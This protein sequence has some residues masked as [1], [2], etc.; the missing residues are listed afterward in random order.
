MNTVEPGEQE[1][2]RQALVREAVVND[3]PEGL[4]G[5]GLAAQVPGVKVDAVVDPQLVAL[6]RACDA[7]VEIERFLVAPAFIGLE[8]LVDQ[9]RGDDL[10][11]VVGVDRVARP[12]A[13]WYVST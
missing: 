1:L 2:D 10:V 6:G 5:L 8:G 11:P 12:R 4:L 7:P 9:G 13:A 3:A